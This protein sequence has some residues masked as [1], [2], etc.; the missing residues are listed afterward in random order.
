LAAL[1][2]ETL[3][4]THFDLFDFLEKPSKAV[5]LDE[6]AEAWRYQEISIGVAGLGNLANESNLLSKV[7]GAWG[8][9][10]K[11][12]ASE[13]ARRREPCDWPHPCALDL[14]FR[15]QTQIDVDGRKVWIPKPFVLQAD[16][17][18]QNL[19]VRLHILGKASQLA[20]GMGERLVEALRERVYWPDLAQNRFVPQNIEILFL[21]KKVRSIE[22]K[23]F[24]DRAV[25]RFITPIDANK[26]DIADKPSG[27]L[28][29]LM[30]R[31]LTLARW[32]GFDL[33][34]DLAEF[35]QLAENFTYDLSYLG[36]RSEFTRGEKHSKKVYSNFVRGGDLIIEGDVRKISP[37]L[38]I[39]ETCHAGR[40]AVAGLGRFV[41]EKS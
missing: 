7:R 28:L 34:I 21:K 16:P 14:F 25:V 38:L 12:G 15:N 23:T 6:L 5:N 10:L 3:S 37:L 26:S 11:A 18:G 22:K 13:A 35:R 32:H 17:V 27:F 30:K 1:R 33:Q 31:V 41:V 29:R 39:G 2:L 19:L 40:G 24:G 8:E 9:A 4:E 20:A 36:E